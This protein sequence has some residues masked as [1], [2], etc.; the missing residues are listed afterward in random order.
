MS[1]RLNSDCIYK[2]FEIFLLNSA[3][4]NPGAELLEHLSGVVSKSF[5]RRKNSRLIFVPIIAIGIAAA[6]L[7][8]VA[9]LWAG[10]ESD[11][12]A[13][14]RQKELV[15]TKLAD[16][17]NQVAADVAVIA[18]GYA[19]LLPGSVPGSKSS[20]YG[21]VRRFGETITAVFGME[22]MLLVD[23]QGDLILDGDAAIARRYQW[24]RPL[25]ADFFERV[26]DDRLRTTAGRQDNGSPVASRAEILRLEGRASITS[27]SPVN[28]SGPD[29]TIEPQAQY[30]LIAFRFLDGIVLD[31]LSRE[32]GLK[33]ARY[34]RTLDATDGEVAFQVEASATGDPIGVIIWTPDLPG[35][36]V[37]EKLTPYLCAAIA[38]IGGLFWLLVRRLNRSWKE[39]RRSE[40]HAKELALLDV[41]TRL[42]NRDLFARRLDECSASTSSDI[43]IVVGFID[44]D[45]F[46]AVNDSFGHAVGDELIIEAAAR[47]NEVL[48]GRGTLA[49]LGGDEFAVLLMLQQQD[50]AFHAD[51]FEK[52][53]SEI[54]R[55]F[56][57]RQSEITA[58]IGCSIGIASSTGRH[59]P[60]EELLRR[61]DVALYQAKAKG[62][63]CLVVYHAEIETA[64]RE[65]ERLV[66]ELRTELSRIGAASLRNSDMG[67]SS[68][69]AL[70]IHFQ[71]IHRA[72]DESKVSGAEALVRWR[73]PRL[74]LLS[75]DRFIPLAESIGL[76]DELG[77]FILKQA[78][79]IG[80][81]RLPNKTIAVNVSPRQL[82][83]SR[84]ADSVL[85]I[86]RRA[87]FAPSCLELELTET[88]LV[89]NPEQAKETLSQL[90]GEGV[91][92]ALDD[93]GTGYSSLS[94]LIHFGI[95]RIKI[96]RS[97]VRLLD[98]QSNGA[99]VAAAVT[100]L[101]R[102]LGIETTAEGVETKGQ[103]DFLVA[104]GCNDLQGFLF[105]RPVIAEELKAHE[106][107]TQ[108]SRPTHEF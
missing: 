20:D 17:V 21:E 54:R 104:I 29:G 51:V 11:L 47:M 50:I 85:A 89:D 72:G 75:P 105:S 44:L 90:R 78:C 48:H 100:S 69:P 32:M 93:F 77:E 82:R 96:D 58:Y 38:V 40:Q 94:H 37:I 59:C 31:E 92:I 81:S 102:N 28:F 83:N 36:R 67:A 76:I 42:P 39:L 108:V 27:I 101:A 60:P 16:Q 61:A 88:A 1:D 30:F 45:R 6:L 64:Q 25:L 97:F 70:E 15:T 79:L 10:V 56:S 74:G 84:F 3:T 23:R 4:Q 24:V 103:R 53:I 91:K 99:A 86:L 8:V 13:L 73:H 5:S 95:D 52:I 57:L 87:E 80:R 35:S 14:E 34:A 49:R 71:T 22:Q 107:E 12:A 19:S 33:G 63:G 98:T 55:P 18:N 65:R 62:R 9:T 2:C 26:R 41:L 46:K 106:H 68:R 43:G 66:D 7:A